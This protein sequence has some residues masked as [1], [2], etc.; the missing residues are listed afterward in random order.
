MLS[1]SFA[2]LRDL[3][4]ATRLRLRLGGP[5]W[6]LGL[7]F[8]FDEN[9]AFG[10]EYRMHFYFGDDQAGVPVDGGHRQV[11]VSVAAYW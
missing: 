8:F 9:A 2:L 4:L 11:A 3:L 7:E 1:L 6:G 5:Y 10:V